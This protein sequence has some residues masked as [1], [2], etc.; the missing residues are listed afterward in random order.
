MDIDARERDI[1][2][3]ALNNRYN[4]LM[5]H[6]DG[7]KPNSVERDMLNHHMQE[8]LDLQKKIKKAP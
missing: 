1:L 2:H 4:L 7:E 6:W 5:K 8:V 3:E